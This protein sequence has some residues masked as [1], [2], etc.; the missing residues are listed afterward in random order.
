M[1][2]PRC[3]SA[4]Y[5]RLA[6]ARLFRTRLPHWTPC[7]WCIARAYLAARVTLRK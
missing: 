7:G 3:R 4:F 1:M 6:F 2:C 5:I